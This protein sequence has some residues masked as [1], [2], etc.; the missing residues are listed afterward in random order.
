MSFK[1]LFSQQA[2]AYAR[3]RPTY[4]PALFDWVA[5]QA[6]ARGLAVDV[7]TGNGQAAV[8]LAARFRRVI[9]VDPSAKQIANAEAAGNVE[10]RVGASEPNGV[11]AASA[12]LLTVA[13]ALH[14]FHHEKFWAEVRRVLRPGGALAF[15]CYGITDITPE[16]NA[17]VHE[18]YETLLARYWE[19][20]RKLVET[21]YRDVE[22]PFPELA[23]PK[24][25]IRV[26]WT[27]AELTGYLGTWSPIPKYVAAHGEDPLEL[28]RP[29]LAR[30]W[31]DAERRPIRWPL[32]VRAFRV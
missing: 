4:P 11:D 6:P 2:S 32:S 12:D 27:L 8:A 10:Y 20:A 5:A 30:A 1:D 18:L 9:G 7:G 19:P 15:W 24:L 29:R 14:R 13:Q 31:G 22:V 17:A 26:D 28:V 23:A 16:V 25:E 3:F 21:G